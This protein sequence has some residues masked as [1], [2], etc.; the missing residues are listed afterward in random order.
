MHRLAV[1]VNKTYIGVCINI[2]N[3]NKNGENGGSLA[4]T[5]LLRYHE[6]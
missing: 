4:I 6:R 1:T 3:N 2:R 5:R